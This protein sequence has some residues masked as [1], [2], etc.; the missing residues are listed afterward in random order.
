MVEP[1]SFPVDRLRH[2]E[3][4]KKPLVLVAC[5]SF[6]P[7]TFLHLR[8]FEMARDHAS[9]NGF[10]VVGGYM[11]PVNDAYRKKGLAGS[12]HRVSMCNLAV[13]DS[14]WL[15][16]DPWEALQPNYSPTA[17]VLDH[18]NDE[19]NVK[20][21]GIQVVITDEWTGEQRIERR[22]ARI[23]LLAGSDLI[24]TMSEPGVWSEKDL[25]HI[26]GLYGCYIIERAES[27]IDRSI[28]SSSSVHSR[29]P[30]ALYKDN[31]AFVEQLVRNDV[32]ST[33]IRLFVRKGLSVMYLLPTSVAQ[34]IERFG[35]YRQG[36]QSRKGSYRDLPAMNPVPE[37]GA[38]TSSSLSS[39]FSL[40]S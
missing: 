39:P 23:M 29:S 37:L 34:Y 15:M 16:V 4:Q 11:S 32:S 5:G 6:S 28:F 14:E 10:A 1:Y 18:F 3:E 36:D 7:V 22:P 38:S 25:H 20:G 12:D 2:L 30:L 26:L 19:I 8:M 31:I 24:L 40:S 35:L 33:K 17:Q 21:G 27:E 13:Q 9:S